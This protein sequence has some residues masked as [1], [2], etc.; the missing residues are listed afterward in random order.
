MMGYG[1]QQAPIDLEGGRVPVVFAIRGDAAPGR[2]VRAPFD[3]GVREIRSCK[4]GSD[5]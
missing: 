3:Q 2:E 1:G 5:Y 4:A